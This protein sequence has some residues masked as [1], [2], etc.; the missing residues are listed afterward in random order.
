MLKTVGPWTSK[1]FV[2]ASPVDG[3]SSP[4][5]SLNKDACAAAPGGGCFSQH[6]DSYVL[7]KQCAFG[8]YDV[9]CGQRLV[10]ST[11][12]NMLVFRRPHN[13]QLRDFLRHL[14]LDVLHGRFPFFCKRQ[15][16]AEQAAA[17]LR[18]EFARLG[19]EHATLHSEVMGMFLED[20]QEACRFMGGVTGSEHVVVSLN[21][22][23]KTNIEG[24][25]HRG[26]LRFHINYD[27][28]RLSTTYVGPGIEYIPEHHL[29]R[30]TDGSIVFDRDA[31]IECIHEQEACVMKGNAFDPLSAEGVGVVH[32][33][34]RLREDDPNDFQLV[35]KIDAVTKRNAN[36]FVM[37]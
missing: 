19:V 16:P 23:D 15:M 10:Q 7:T 20:V 13:P 2:M 4:S 26:P 27:T 22:V 21:V 35:L 33:Y 28:L 36:G 32:R 12:L 31:Q 29:K 24:P 37:Y 25:L 18:E 5:H 30:H 9:S 14:F 3:V 34:P 11:Q 1:A 17:G 6:E 8:E